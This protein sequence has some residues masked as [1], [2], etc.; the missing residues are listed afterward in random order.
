MS[1]SKVRGYSTY[2]KK[3]HFKHC[4]I[5]Y[6]SA[7]TC[8]YPGHPWRFCQYWYSVQ[9]YQEPNAG[10]PSWYFSTTPYSSYLV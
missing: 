6:Y 1:K 4:T 10:N 8:I 7:S 3:A 2:C 5:D 9:R